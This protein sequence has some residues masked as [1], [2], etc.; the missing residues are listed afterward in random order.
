MTWWGGRRR[1]LDRADKVQLFSMVGLFVIGAGFLVAAVVRSF[2]FP[3]TIPDHI[4]FVGLF[5]LISFCCVFVGMVF[6]FIAAGR[7]TRRI[8]RERH[9]PRV[10]L[11]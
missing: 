6:G 10:P 8:Y 9:L 11:F 1:K 3:Q 5:I 2:F 7:A 4:P